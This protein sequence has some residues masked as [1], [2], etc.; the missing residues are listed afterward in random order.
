[1]GRGG[2][3]SAGGAG[4][5]GQQPLGQAAA[6][7]AVGAGVG[8]A[9]AQA[10]G[11]APGEEAGDG[12]AAGVVGVEHLGEED[13]QG[14][15]G[16][17]QAFAERDGLLAEGLLDRFGAQDVGERQP[18]GLGELSPQDAGWAGAASG[19]RVSH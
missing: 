14:D 19:G 9:G 10:A 7:L 15:Q 16:R 11:G 18:G 6:G 3:P 5:A 13:P 8:G 1:G 17:V 2:G 4:Q 12:G